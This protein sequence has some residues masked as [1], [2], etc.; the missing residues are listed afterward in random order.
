MSFTVSSAKRLEEQN[1]AQSID[2][3][4]TKQAFVVSVTEK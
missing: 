2:W 4:T 3:R 1:V